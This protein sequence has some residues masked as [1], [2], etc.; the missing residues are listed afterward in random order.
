MSELRIRD[1]MNPSVIAVTADCT[2][3]HIVDVITDLGV[4]G[5]P[6]VSDDNRVT[7][8]ISE[9]DLLPKVQPDA[10]AAGGRRHR[11]AADTRLHDGV[12]TLGGTA[13]RRST[14]THTARQVRT[15]EGVTGVVDEIACQVEDEPADRPRVLDAEL[16]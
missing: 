3:Q 15:L 10:G 4:G 14:A 9:A 8:V 13:D 2:Y 12:V 11:A 5:M 1:V 7:G 16:R 6:V